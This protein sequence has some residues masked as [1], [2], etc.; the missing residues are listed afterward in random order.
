MMTSQCMTDDDVIKEFVD[1]SGPRWGSEVD[2][3]WFQEII[4]SSFTFLITVNVNE[5]VFIS[6]ERA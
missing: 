3:F 5:K 1:R 2:V 6:I 4:K